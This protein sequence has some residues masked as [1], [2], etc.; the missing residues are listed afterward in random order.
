MK[1]LIFDRRVRVLFTLV[2]LSRATS[3]NVGLFLRTAQRP[4]F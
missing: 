3:F 4:F 2:L 1:V